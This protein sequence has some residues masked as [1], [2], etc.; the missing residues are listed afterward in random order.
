MEFM[1]PFPG[2]ELY[3]IADQYGTFDKDW[4]KMIVFK[5]PIF[6]PNGLTKEELIKWNK[7]GFWSFYLQPRIIFSYIKNVSN[8]RELKM[9][10]VGGLTLIGWVLK[11]LLDIESKERG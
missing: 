7:R 9:I 1:V 4:R 6:I 3:Q 2:T 10:M 5:D 8:Y 11:S